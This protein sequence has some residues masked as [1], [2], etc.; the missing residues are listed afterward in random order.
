MRYA[1][2]HET[3][4]EVMRKFAAD[5]ARAGIEIEL[6]EVEASVLVLEDTTCTPGPDSPCLWQFSDWNGGWGYGPASTPPVRPCTP[7][8]PPSTSAATATRRRTS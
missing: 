5:A 3:L 7:A 8:A 6:T 1:A 2:G 4:T